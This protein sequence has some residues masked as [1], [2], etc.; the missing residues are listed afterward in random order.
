[1]DGSWRDIKKTLSRFLSEISEFL[2]FYLSN[3]SF[4]RRVSGFDREIFFLAKKFFHVNITFKNLLKNCPGKNVKRSHS[5]FQICPN[6]VFSNEFK[7]TGGQRLNPAPVSD[8][9]KKSTFKNSRDGDRLDF[10]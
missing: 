6:I 10:Q 4:D 7:T 8:I 9:E 2:Q 3:V 5:G 1:V